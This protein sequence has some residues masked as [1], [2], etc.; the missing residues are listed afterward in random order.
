MGMAWNEIS[1]K[2]VS[3]QAISVKFNDIYDKLSREILIF[4]MEQQLYHKPDSLLVSYDKLQSGSLIGKKN[5]L[6]SEVNV[7]ILGVDPRPLGYINQNR[8]IK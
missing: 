5:W 2:M 3:I 6:Q 1:S 4:C 8:G 7:K